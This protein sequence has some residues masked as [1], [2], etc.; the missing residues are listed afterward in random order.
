MGTQRSTA[1]IVGV[2]FIVAS[3]T[4][5]AGGLL[6]VPATETGFLA[7]AAGHEAQVV[8]GA[9]LEFAL[10]VSVFAIAAMLYPILKRESEGLALGYMGLRTLEGALILAGTVAGLLTL[11]LSKGFGPDGASGVQPLGEILLGAREW[12]YWLG[13]MAMF[14]LGALTLYYLLYRSRLVPMWLSLWGFGGAL[15]LLSSALLEMFGQALGGWQAVFTAPIG[16]QEMVLAVWLIVKGFDVT[17]IPLE[18]SS[19]R[20]TVGVAMRV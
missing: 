10:A 14:S 13:P 18:E 19:E 5:I 3:A 17:H 1:R 7:D 4:A 8:F 12:T 6:M 20:L 9:L 2:L 16:L 15:L 11:T